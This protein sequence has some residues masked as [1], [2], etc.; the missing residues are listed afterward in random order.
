MPRNPRK[1][2][3]QPMRAP[4]GLPQGERKQI[5]DAQ[6]GVPLPNSE[7]RLA[8]ATD[9]AAQMQQQQPLGGDLL[10]Q[11]TAR[12]EEPLTAGMNLGAGPGPEAIPPV[13]APAD[14]DNSNMARY[15][16]ML[17]TLADQPGASNA[18]RNLVRR[19]RGSLPLSATQAALIERNS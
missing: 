17:E 11:P 2:S 14:Q 9:Q 18:T 1:S 19:M 5:M 16:P 10:S 4:S 13:I 3:E 8:L 12:P 7:G 6:A 15:M